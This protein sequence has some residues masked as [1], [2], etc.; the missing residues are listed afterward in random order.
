VTPGAAD[1][2]GQVDGPNEAGDFKQGLA[3]E[4]SGG[5]AQQADP[6]ADLRIPR[7]HQN[8]VKDYFN[9]SREGK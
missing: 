4:G 2:G 9:Q 3:Q 5:P 8:H 7:K 1:Y 6:L